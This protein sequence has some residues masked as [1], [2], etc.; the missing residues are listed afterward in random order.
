MLSIDA[1]FA[2]FFTKLPFDAPNW[3]VIIGGCSL[4]VVVFGGQY[5][6]L[7]PFQSYFCKG[8]SRRLEVCRAGLKWSST[9]AL[10]LSREPKWVKESF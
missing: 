3:R 4:V 8:H 2:L 5:Q 10:N 6:P 7:K 9:P 1:T